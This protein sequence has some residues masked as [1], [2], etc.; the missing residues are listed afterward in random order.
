MAHL[1]LDLDRVSVDGMTIAYRAIG[2]GPPLLLLHGWPT[3][4]FLW[5]KVM[6]ALARA[7][8]RVLAPDLPG[9]GASDKPL[10]VHYGFAFFDRVVD[11][12]LD[13]VG[14]RDAAV[15]MV[16]HDIGGPIGLNW[17][18]ERPARLERLALLNTLAYPQL[19]ESVVAF[20]RGLVEPATRERLTSPE[21]LTD[22]LRDGFANPDKLTPDA[23]AAYL[24]PFAAADARRA[25]ADACVGLERRG[26][27]RIAARLP[28]LA[29]PVR[30]VYGARDRVLPD[31]GQ[32][33][34]HVARDLPHAEVTVLPERGHFIPDEAPDEVGAAL[35]AFFAP[36]RP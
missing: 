7:G 2:E 16:V 10:G 25:L 32:T 12:F 14:L 20:I 22:L 36:R 18:L 3:S 9:F 4:S 15:G 34:A 11:G 19:H 35:A 29:V 5:R 8:R 28:T 21:G 23:L 31:V 13:A 17:A 27:A 26:L 33:M 24:A 1:D 6:P 30:V